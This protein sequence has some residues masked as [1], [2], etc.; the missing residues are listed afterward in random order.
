MKKQM[1]I[2]LCGVGLLFALIFGWKGF[3][4]IMTKQYLATMQQ[5]AVTIST[6]TVDNSQWQAQLKA[7]GSL[8]AKVG[9][10]VTTELAGMVQAMPFI[11]GSEVE[12]GA[13]LIQLNAAS[14]LG[15]LHALQAQVELA[16]ITFKRDQAQFKAHAV[17]KQIVDGDEW[18]LKNLQAQVEQQ[19]ATVEKKTIRA[20]FSGHIGINN[21]NVGQYLN[22]GD[23]ITSLQ[24]L[25][26][27][28]ADF[29]LPQQ[30]LAQLKM[31]QVVNIMTDTF[32]EQKF[33]GKITTIQPSVDAA[34]RNV[35]VEAT[36]PN[37]DFKLRPGMFVQVAVNASKPQSFLTIPQSAI[38]FNPYG[39]IVF[40]VKDSG[41]KDKNEQPILV[42][43]QVFVTVGDTRGDQIAVL[44]GLKKGDI[45]V[46][47]GQLKLKN[48]S[49]V[50][51]NNTV[52]PSN[53][54]APSAKALEK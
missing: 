21:V 36:V 6:Y 39:D 10:N 51:I 54:A 25:D 26:P 35:Q 14:E 50:V 20:P 53:D 12:K 19:A 48:D 2:M 44:K 29:Y 18:N 27:L 30:A 16:K 23:V 49:T 1:I 41:K 31:N 42:S 7:V 38:S 52:Q 4:A 11:P 15:Q 13:V 47:S 24:A 40:I 45:I 3:K 46:T 9:V 8:R 22:V 28:Y 17:S 37:A 34:T 32:P 43:E 5:P 33:S